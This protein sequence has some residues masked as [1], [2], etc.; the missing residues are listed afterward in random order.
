MRENELLPLPDLRRQIHDLTLMKRSTGLSPPE[1][2]MLE[3]LESI[4]YSLTE[5]R[6]I[7]SC[8]DSAT[9]YKKQRRIFT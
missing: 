9:I 3:Q 5:V 4:E 2:H 8:S 1:E 6:A 7:L